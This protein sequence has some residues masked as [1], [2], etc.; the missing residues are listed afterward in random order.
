MSLLLQDFASGVALHLTRGRLPEGG[1]EQGGCPQ[2]FS[3]LP[4]WCGKASNWK[5]RSH[6]KAGGGKM[7]ALRE[8]R[9]LRRARSG[10]R[11]CLTALENGEKQIKNKSAKESLRFLPC[12]GV[13]IAHLQLT[14]AETEVKCS[15]P[16]L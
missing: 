9:E 13:N 14:G 10:N 15:H 12:L 5:R 16:T 11:I 6:V 2:R 3:S 1:R 7:I 4:C 8:Q